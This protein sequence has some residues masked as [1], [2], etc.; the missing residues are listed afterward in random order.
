MT[1]NLLG[2]ATGD[3]WFPITKGQLYAKSFYAIMFHGHMNG[4]AATPKTASPHT[5]ADNAERALMRMY[6]HDG[7][8]AIQ[9]FLTNSSSVQGPTYQ[10]WS[11]CDCSIC[12]LH[13]HAVTWGRLEKWTRLTEWTYFHAIWTSLCAL[14]SFETFYV[15][16]TFKNLLNL[17][18]VFITLLINQNDFVFI[19]ILKNK[20]IIILNP[21]VKSITMTGVQGGKSYLTNIAVKIRRP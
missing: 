21:I 1:G 8:S 16:Q 15:N 2:E 14:D 11:T 17:V 9:P 19:Y 13:T 5:G 20:S 6:R 4:T 18:A 3:R 7:S 10:I 12:F